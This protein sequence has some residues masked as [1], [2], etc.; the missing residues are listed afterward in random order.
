MRVALW[1]SAVALV[2]TYLASP[3]SQ[4]VGELSLASITGG[5]GNCQV[6]VK[7][8]S[9]ACNTC[10]AVEDECTS[11][12]FFWKC[13]T[14][15]DPYSSQSCTTSYQLCGGRQLQ[16]ST[17]NCSG[18]ATDTGACVRNKNVTTTVSGSGTCP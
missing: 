7:N 5:D 2:V 14:Y 9:F 1:L 6:G 17:A 11:T 16:Y 10:G 8:N 3:S 18:P 13:N 12:D 15:K 4:A